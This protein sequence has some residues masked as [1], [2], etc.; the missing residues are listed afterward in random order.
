MSSPSSDFHPGPVPHSHSLPR[1]HAGRVVM[2]VIDRVYSKTPSFDELFDE[3]TFYVFAAC[4]TALTC[5]A[6]FVASR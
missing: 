5:L 1:G 3:E 2:Q 6:A 4:F